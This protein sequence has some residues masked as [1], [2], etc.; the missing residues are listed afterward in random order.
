MKAIVQLSKVLFLIAFVYLNE[1]VTIS[2]KLF[3]IMNKRYIAAGFSACLLQLQPILIAPVYGVSGGG[4]DYATKDIRGEDFSTQNLVGKDFTQCDGTGTSFKNAKLNGA[5]F[6]RANLKDADFSN[7]DLSSASLEDTSLID[8]IFENSNLQG[9]YFSSSILDA[10]SIKGADFTDALM[11]DFVKNKLCVRIDISD[12]NS[13]T[14]V[15]TSES[16]F[17]E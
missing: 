12:S 14:G 5:R 4:K 1:S 16:L 10:K 17:C 15:K 9:A 2:T 8:T 13:R 6:Y 3:K 11:P 7:A